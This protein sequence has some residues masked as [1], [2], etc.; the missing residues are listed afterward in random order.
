MEVAQLL[1]ASAIG[2]VAANFFVVGVRLLFGSHNAYEM[3]RQ[4]SRGAFATM[5]GDTEKDE[6]DGYVRVEHGTAFTFNRKTGK[7]RIVPQ[8]SL[9]NDSL[10]ETLK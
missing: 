4:V 9:S 10:L 2:L 1:V 6:V 5:R 7:K 8:S 3:N